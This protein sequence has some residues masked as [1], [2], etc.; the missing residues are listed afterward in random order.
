M[1]HWADSLGEAL[2]PPGQ[3]DEAHAVSAHVSV[4]HTEQPCHL[5][6]WENR[7]A[8]VL[9]AL[10]GPGLP[11]AHGLQGQRRMFLK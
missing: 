3:W 4:L 6:L 1:S 2:P 7:Q 9:G 8:R 5:F 10:R 11:A